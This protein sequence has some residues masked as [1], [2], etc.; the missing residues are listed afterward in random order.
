MFVLRYYNSIKKPATLVEVNEDGFII[1]LH[2][3]RIVIYKLSTQELQVLNKF[4][5]VP[6]STMVIIPEL[7]SQQQV[8]EMLEHKWQKYMKSQQQ[9]HLSNESP[10][11]QKLQTSTLY[12]TRHQNKTTH[13]PNP[14]AD[15]LQVDYRPPLK[16]SRSLTTT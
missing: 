11:I 2:D 7:T 16:R 5:Y 4:V 3:E 14:E 8:I 13:Y 6:I 15:I 9:E 12:T 1:D 10:T